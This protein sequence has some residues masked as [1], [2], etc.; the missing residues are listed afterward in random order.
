LESATEVCAR[1]RLLADAPVDRVI[2]V[3]PRTTPSMCAPEAAVT[4]PVTT[5]TMLLATAPPARTIFTFDE[6]V[7]VPPTWKIHV[8]VAPPVMVMVLATVTALFQLYK[9]GVRIRPPIAPVARLTKLGFDRPFASVNA[10]AM[11]PTATVR[12]EGVGVAYEAAKIFPVTWVEVENCPVESRMRE[13]PVRPGAAMGLTPMAPVI[14]EGERFETPALA[15][16]A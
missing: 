3:C 16:I 14:T 8:S 5:Q 6:T 7:S 10:V 12:V 1:S 13:N 11:S 15:R 9:P 4:A 2:D